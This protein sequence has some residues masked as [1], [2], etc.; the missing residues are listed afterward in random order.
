M[1][2]ARFTRLVGTPVRRREDVALLTGK[3]TYV[4]DVRVPGMLHMRVLRSPYAHARIRRIDCG[5]AL[6]LPGVVAVITGSEAEGLVPPLPTMSQAIPDLKVP[7]HH[8]LAVDKVRFAG[9]GVAAVVAADAY[10]ACDAV[11]LIE[12][13]YD[14]LPVVIDPE[15]AM[16]PDSP[17]LHAELGDNIA[18]RLRL[19]GNVDEALRQSDLVVRQRLENQRVIANPMET[20]GIVAHYQPD[21]EKLTAWVATQVPHVLRT[22]LA[23]LLGLPENR[24]RVIAPDVGGAF[25]TKVNIYAEEVLAAA[26]SMR[27]GRPIKW[28]EDRDEH[29]LATTHGRGQA[30]VVE[31]GVR[32]D[33]TL[34]ALRVR[35]TA[36][37]GAYLQ[38]MT[39]VIPT[40]TAVAVTGCYRVPACEV[41]VVGIFTNKTPTD[42]YRGA[43]RPEATYYI[44]R[45]LDLVARRLGMDPVAVRRR[46]FVK[47]DEFPYTTAMGLVLDTGD[48]DLTLDRALERLDYA[49]FRSEQERL[50]QQGRYLGVGFSTWVEQC[51]F[52]PTAHMVPGFAPGGWE[53]ATVRVDSSGGVTVLT[54]TSPHGQGVETTFAMLTADELGVPIADVRVIHGD[55]DAVP[56]GIGTMSARSLA[57]G[58]SALLLC[59]RALKEKAKRIAAES[60]GTNWED[61]L[62]EGGRLYLRDSPEK[63][64]SFQEM[65][66]LAYR[67]GGRPAGMEPGLEASSTF[68]PPNFTYPFGAHICVVEVEASSG[69]VKILRYIAVDDC[70]FVVNPAV[71][72]GQIQGGIV[73]GVGQALIEAALYSEDAQ[74]LTGSLMDYL[75]PDCTLLPEIEMERTETLTPVNPLGAKGVGESGALAAPPAVVNAVMDALAPLGVRHIDMPLTPEKIWRAVRYATRQV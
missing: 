40:L 18:Y 3:G 34:T 33:G 7:A 2:A 51:S 30:A 4:D 37:L 68:D 28:I 36:D 35:I 38:M 43:G 60:L 49:G 44:E 41:E 13:D 22:N 50:R 75:L 66:T 69:D 71:V 39:H 58:G 21:G 1:Q 55:T 53:A 56:Q 54:G 25:G 9:E 12:V 74:L 6:A 10:V 67:G 14:P 61:L 59:L 27:L 62:Y 45:L 48:Y 63:G 46:N 26:L 72:E 5:A 52:G 16:A 8:V 17:V 47:S 31:A 24:V 57:V 32:Q 11:E 23:R 64:I 19:G 65:V 70:G 42:A 20:R 15:K 29:M 73:Q